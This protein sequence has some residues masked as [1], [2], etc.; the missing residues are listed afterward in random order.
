LTRAWSCNTLWSTIFGWGVFPPV[1]VSIIFIANGTYTMFWMYHINIMTWEHILYVSDD[2]QKPHKRIPKPSI[3]KTVDLHST[4]SM[5]KHNWKVISTA[6]NNQKL[7]ID[8][9]EVSVTW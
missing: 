4:L 7:H 3:F 6:P 2:Q 5:S 1:K 8:K 9:G